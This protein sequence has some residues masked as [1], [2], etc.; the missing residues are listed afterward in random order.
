[1][2]LI[3]EILRS[4]AENAQI[5]NITSLQLCSEMIVACC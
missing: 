1:M 4:Y 3:N 2:T 5:A